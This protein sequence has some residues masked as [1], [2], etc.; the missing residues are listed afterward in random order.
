MLNIGWAVNDFTPQRPAMI[1]GQ[2]H[3]RIGREAIDP[4]TLAVLAIE[5]GEPRDCAILI[6]LDL[7]MIPSELIESVREK[8]RR[9]IP[10]FPSDRLVMMGTHTHT[11]LVIEGQYYE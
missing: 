2:M 4:L 11:A 6:S 1:Q 8:L 7:P 5:G 3:R 9:L 10:D